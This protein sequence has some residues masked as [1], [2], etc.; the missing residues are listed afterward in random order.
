MIN[1]IGFNHPF[2]FQYFECLMIACGGDLTF[3][4]E[5]IHKTLE[6]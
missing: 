6:T 1:N 5:W 2:L 4:F 3:G